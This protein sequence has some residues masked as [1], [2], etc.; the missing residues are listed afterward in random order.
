MLV[1][2]IVAQVLFDDCMPILS[3]YPT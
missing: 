3:F 1:S 2:V